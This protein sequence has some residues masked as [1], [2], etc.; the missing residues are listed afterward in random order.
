MCKSENNEC[1]DESSSGKK[2]TLECVPCGKL[3]TILS[4]NTAMRNE[5]E[6]NINNNE[7]VI[8]H[9]ETWSK[10][11]ESLKYSNVCGN[12]SSS[13][14][15]QQ[16]TVKPSMSVRQ[17]QLSATAKNSLRYKCSSLVADSTKIT[18]Q[19]GEIYAKFVSASFEATNTNYDTALFVND[20]AYATLYEE[21]CNNIGRLLVKNESSLDWT[22]FVVITLVVVVALFILVSVAVVCYRKKFKILSRQIFCKY[23]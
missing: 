5:F 1:I 19:H 21:F 6:E 22:L 7:Q 10:K 18:A 17:A 12:S 13:S 15:S 3:I 14:N 23:F 4:L 16:Q 8:K 11:P 2:N 20:D 9:N